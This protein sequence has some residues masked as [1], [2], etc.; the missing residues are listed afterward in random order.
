MYFGWLHKKKPDYCS[1]KV[2]KKSFYGRFRV[3]EYFSTTRNDRICLS[4]RALPETY[5]GMNLCI[6]I[7]YTRKHPKTAVSK[8]SKKVFMVDFG[9]SNIFRLLETIEFFFVLGHF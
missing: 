7:D 8:S 9:F 5:I 6:L 1:I 3:F 4:P 2:L